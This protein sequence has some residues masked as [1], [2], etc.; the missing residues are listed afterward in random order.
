[1]E[2]I[3]GGRSSSGCVESKILRLPRGH[4]VEAS[5]YS[6]LQLRK[7]VWAELGLQGELELPG[8]C[9][10]V[11]LFSC[12][13]EADLLVIQGSSCGLLILCAPC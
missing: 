8:N 2:P 1:M 7:E 6:N 5:R 4:L 3:S 9:C 10:Q 11:T 12:Y 13:C